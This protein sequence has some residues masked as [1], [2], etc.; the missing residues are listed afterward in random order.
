[1]FERP[2]TRDRVESAEALGR[3]LPRVV[4]VNV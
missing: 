4:E 3:Q 1:M 2:E